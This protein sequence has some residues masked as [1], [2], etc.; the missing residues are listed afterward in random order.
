[1]A[2]E[3]SGGTNFNSRVTEPQIRE[4][5]A[6]LDSQKELISSFVSALNTRIEEKHKSFHDLFAELDRRY[7]QRFEAQEMAVKAAF[8]AQERAMSA[9][10]A[11]QEKLYET[12]FTASKQAIDKAEAAQKDKNEMMNEFR[13]QLGDQAS[14]F[15]PRK[16]VEVLVGGNRALYETLKSDLYIQREE[17][18]KNI[19][20][21]DDD[22]KREISN[23]RETG[24]RHVGREEQTRDDK[25]NHNWA[26]GIGLTVAGLL[27]SFAVLIT[28]IVK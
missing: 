26:I 25:T 4:V 15:I 9:A 22:N 3:I 23:L 24:S 1:M 19:S 2:D 20:K 11:A 18:L 6:A 27:I 5:A 12:A 16:E 10:F 13:K 7:Q 28:H 8:A 21:K 14:T 17:M